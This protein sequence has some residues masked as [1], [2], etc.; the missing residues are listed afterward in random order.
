MIFQQHLVSRLF[1]FWLLNDIMNIANS[2][3]L[4]VVLIE[5]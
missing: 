5:S 4:M 3:Y 1:G 2:W